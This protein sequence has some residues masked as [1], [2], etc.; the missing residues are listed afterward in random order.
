[1][2][3]QRADP[4]STLRFCRDLLAL[5]QAEFGGRVAAYQQLPG[6]P[7]LWAYQA[8]GLVVLANFTSEAL[9]LDQP[10]GPVLLAAGPLATRSPVTTLS[11]WQGVITRAGASPA[12]PG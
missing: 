10:P 7:G 4:A 2:A 11:P 6:P 5:R 9:P 12:A 3:D 8:G 1:M